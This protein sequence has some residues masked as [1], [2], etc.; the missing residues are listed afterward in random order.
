MRCLHPLRT[1][2][3]LA[4]SILTCLAPCAIAETTVD[5]TNATVLTRSGKLP[6]AE[7]SAATV[8]VEELAT[9]TGVALPKQAK[10]PK[11]GTV[12]AIATANAK[13]IGGM[14]VP[15][16]TGKDLPEY[17]PD[18]YRLF[19]DTANA[20]TPV[21]WIIGA[22]AR[23][24]LFGVGALLRNTMWAKGS[25]SVP[26]S[27]DIATSPQWPIRGHQLGFRTAANSW[28][29]WT[30]AQYDQYIREIALFG[31]NSIENIPFQDERPIP[32]AKVSRE[33]MNIRMSEICE[34][35]GLDYWV[36]TPADFDL[37]DAAARAV[38]L[39]K[40]EA[41]YRATPTLTGVFF[42]GG[43]PGDNPP[44]LV[45]P[46]LEDLSKRL[47]KHHPKARIW[48]SLQGFSKQHVDETF[49]FIERERPTW[50]EG[51]CEGPSSPP[52]AE[53]RQRLSRDY[54]LRMYPDL[55]HNKIC[56]YEVPWWD[57]AYA[58][59]LG[60]EA[61]NPRP[62][63]YAYL[64][65]WFAPMCDGFIS[66]SDGVHDDVNKTVWSALS[67]DPNTPVR[68]IVREYCNLF[69][70]TKVA[71]AST[72]GVFALEKNWRGPLPDNGS[73][74]GTLLLWQQLEEA[75][76]ELSGN[77]RWQMCVVRAYYD[78]HIRRRLLHELELEDEANAILLDAPKRGADK[79][80][81]DALAVLNRATTEQSSPELRARIV[82]LYDDLY[83]SIQL[84][85][86]VDKYQ[87]SGYERGASL[88]FID[89]PLNN[90]FWLEDEFKKVT[91]MPTEAEKVARL[92]AIANW[93]NPG[94]GG[95]YDN[96]GNTRKSDHVLHSEFIY[97][98]V[99]EGA[100]SGPL[101]W[102][103]DEGK[104]RQRLTWQISM[105]F[106][107]ALVYEGLDQ[108]KAYIVKAN[109]IGQTLL[110]IDGERV[111]PRIDSRVLGEIREFDV[112]AAALAD[113]KLELTFDYP[114][115]EG[116][117]NWRQRSHLSEI[118]LVKS[119]SK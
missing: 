93:E 36:W 60:R 25:A 86:S 66:Y 98:N 118:W 65:N 41:F 19:V 5:L 50:L 1:V 62:A 77:W 13:K 4:L 9:R 30:V 32:N 64:H 90:R 52:I 47:V 55:T 89:L 67:W 114:T 80:I 84:Q 71:E 115:D 10:R 95:Y 94:P 2:A 34:R 53:L 56:Q 102:W 44:S 106:P 88:D 100:N 48:L 82:A 57:Q 38:A 97:T 54:K 68:D 37:K 45:L 14:R 59:V 78:T 27:L 29:M 113:G 119:Q 17:Q 74:E 18:G 31:A 103:R 15:H 21:V 110:R 116:H 8:L 23:G 79:A 111:A 107:K 26:A 75:A 112:P 16:R 96:V 70:G 43:D 104:S 46:Y 69:F 92:L 99:A 85:S 24:A 42:P 3:L 72:D 58:L 87:A 63:Q 81:A 101:L 11:D 108:N 73:V 109:G 49:E 6:K 117:L 91:A 76:P 22:D 20:S 40:H 33:E 51:L 105:D 7:A 61:I 12:I 39:D 28:D 83:R 35:Y